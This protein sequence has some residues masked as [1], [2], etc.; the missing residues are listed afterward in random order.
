MLHWCRTARA[1]VSLLCLVF[2]GRVSKNETIVCCCLE[3]WVVFVTAAK[4]W[5]ILTDTL[6]GGEERERRLGKPAGLHRSSR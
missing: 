5:R 4:N 6:P 2:F 3:T 1:F